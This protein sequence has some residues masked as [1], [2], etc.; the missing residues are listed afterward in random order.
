MLELIGDVLQVASADREE[1]LRFIYGI[2]MQKEKEGL[3]DYMRHPCS[4]A[5]W[6]VSVEEPSCPQLWEACAC[7]GGGLSGEVY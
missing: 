1:H 5:M 7:L 3:W 4:L 6:M 2:H